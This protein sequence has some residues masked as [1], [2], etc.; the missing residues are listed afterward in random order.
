M[1]EKRHWMQ[2]A[3]RYKPFYEKTANI[4]IF[5]FITSI[6]LQR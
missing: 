1:N 5:P 2:A 6:F 3:K 4:L